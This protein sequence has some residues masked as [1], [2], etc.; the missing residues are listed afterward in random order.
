MMKEKVAMNLILVEQ[1][2]QENEV[3]NFWSTVSVL[4]LKGKVVVQ[5]W[6]VV[7]IVTPCVAL[8]TTVPVA[9]LAA[10]FGKQLWHTDFFY[11][12]IKKRVHLRRPKTTCIP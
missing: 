12:L 1:L 2:F 3:L 4:N 8:G 6:K 11:V 9:A 10:Q 5:W 7:L